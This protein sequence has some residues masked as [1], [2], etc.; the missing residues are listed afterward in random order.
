MEMFKKK[1]FNVPIF[2]SLHRHELCKVSQWRRYN[3][4]KKL[5]VLQCVFSN[6]Q[7]KGP[8]LKIFWNPPSLAGFL[9]DHQNMFKTFQKLFLSFLGSPQTV[10]VNPFCDLV[11]CARFIFPNICLHFNNYLL[12][13]TGQYIFK[14][15]KTLLIFTWP[16]MSL[17]YYL[18]PFNLEFASICL[19]ISSLTQ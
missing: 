18:P 8:F 2:R 17:K 7:Q 14:Q 9:W 3:S 11:G 4:G 16:K 12:S 6:L 13:I 19:I 5:C 1:S 15:N 10:K